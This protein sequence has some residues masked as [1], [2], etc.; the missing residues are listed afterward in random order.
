MK[1]HAVW[2]VLSLTAAVLFAPAAFAEKTPPKPLTFPSPKY[3]AA[4]TDSGRNG[5]VAIDVLVKADGSVAE[6]VLKAADDPAFGVEAM[7]VI[8]QWKFQ[9]ATVDGAPVEIHVEIPFKFRAPFDQKINAMAKRKVYMVLPEPAMTAKEYGK[10]KPKGT[11][12]P[13]YPPSL[14]KSGI[15]QDLKVNFVV[16]P[17]G[18]VVNPQ[19]E[20]EPASPHL[21]LPAIAAAS[22][23][24]FEPPKKKGKAVYV[25]GT[26]TLHFE[27]PPPGEGRGGR[28]KG[29]GGRGGGD[30]GEP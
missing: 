4:L 28:G 9:P 16:T 2:S 18:N 6:P 7:A 25:E 24:T 26:T 10:L 29:K 20:T 14:A 30:G 11:V 8:D 27:E 12:R 15:K 13:A 23:L 22:Q 17:E 3:P 21:I 5:D 19:F 1:P